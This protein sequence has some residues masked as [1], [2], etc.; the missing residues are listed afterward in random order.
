MGSLLQLTK[1]NAEV[2]KDGDG[3]VTLEAYCTA[4]LGAGDIPSSPS[5][6]KFVQRSCAVPERARVCRVQSREK[7][8]ASIRSRKF[9]GEL[10]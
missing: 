10:T 7:Q 8:E 5:L 6:P 2:Q 4:I 9:P 3:K 1:F